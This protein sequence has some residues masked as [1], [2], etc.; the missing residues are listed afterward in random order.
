MLIIRE[1]LIEENSFVLCPNEKAGLRT[2]DGP[3]AAY[4]K[5]RNVSRTSLF[6]F[7]AMEFSSE[8]LD[9]ATAGYTSAIEKVL[10]GL[11]T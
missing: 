10:L 9:I 7:S 1:E 4:H 3:C 5:Q 11:S 8:E 6:S 2:R